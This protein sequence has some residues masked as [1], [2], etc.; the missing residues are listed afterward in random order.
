MYK[1]INELVAQ[2]GYRLLGAEDNFAA[3]LIRYFN[4]MYTI[5]YIY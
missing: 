2:R 5:H 4:L 3:L 1:L